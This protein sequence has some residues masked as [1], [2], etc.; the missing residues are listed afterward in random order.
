MDK[1]KYFINMPVRASI[2]MIKMR[3]GYKK[4]T[5]VLDNIQREE[6]EKGIEKG[7]ALCQPRG[8][9]GRF[10]I[11]EHQTDF[12]MLE[13]GQVLKSNSLARLLENSDEVVLMASTVGKQIVDRIVYEINEGD[14]SLGVILDSVASQTADAGLT[15][16]VRYI[17]QHLYREGKRLTKH[18]Y[19]PGY[20]DLPLE[21]QK[22]LFDLLKL[23]KLQLALTESYMLVPE[24]SV[25]A[26]AGIERIDKCE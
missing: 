12:I 19:S 22:I 1:V 16:I 21:N 4:G 11:K 18:R 10:I 5:T 6:L 17:N 15:W 8:A 20:G 23:E 14:A 3:L 25:I 26:I 2:E 13:N 24:K 7:F 9:F